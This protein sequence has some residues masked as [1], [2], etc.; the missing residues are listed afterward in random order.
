[1][2]YYGKIICMRN[3]KRVL[4]TFFGGIRTRNVYH[5]IKLG[6]GGS[7]YNFHIKKERKT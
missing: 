6:R 1:M 7:V 5:C 4:L 2:Y 3:C